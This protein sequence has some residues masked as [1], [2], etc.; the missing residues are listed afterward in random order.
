MQMFLP[1]HAEKFVFFSIVLARLGAMMLTTPLYGSRMIPL[2]IRII[3]VFVLTAVIAP[4][5]WHS[6]IAINGTALLFTLLENIA[7]G[8]TLGFAMLILFSGVQVAGAMV[9]QS[10]QLAA[11]SN[12]NDPT[13]LH[14]PP[15]SQLLPWIALT[16]FVAMGGHRL[17]MTAL[18]DSFQSIPV[19]GGLLPERLLDTALHMVS[20]SFRLAVR[21]AA[22]IIAALL[23]STLVVGLA[24]RALPQINSL[25]VGLTVNLWATFLGLFFSLAVVAYLFQEYVYSFLSAWK[26]M[27]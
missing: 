4:F 21:L 18:L 24:S 15:S 22:P 26:T 14:G 12:S 9:Y 27:L 5:Q 23:A 25:T 2:H 3:S 20:E 6:S 7:I 17:L 16:L 10:G 13:S 11:E 19:T 1:L 8:A